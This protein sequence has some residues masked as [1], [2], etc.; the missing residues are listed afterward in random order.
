M[1]RRYPDYADAY[2]GWNYISS[3]GSIIS[4]GSTVLF[5]YILY[6][7]FLDYKPVSSNPWSVAAYYLDGQAA[8][9]S[10]NS[11]LEWALPAN[12]GLHTYPMLPAQS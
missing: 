12:V 2:A 1:P 3:I 9:E 7:M 11:T 10:N 4:L 5:G 6:D 8:L